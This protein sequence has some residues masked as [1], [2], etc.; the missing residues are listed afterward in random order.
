MHHVEIMTS[1]IVIHIVF[2]LANF[3]LTTTRSRISNGEIDIAYN[4][5]Q[6]SVLSNINFCR[7]RRLD[8][9]V[10]AGCIRLGDSVRAFIPL[11]SF[12][13]P[14]PADCISYAI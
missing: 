2:R 11:L 7:F 5:I 14:R 9:T 6:K 4:L 8:L 12:E 10:F 1:T 13:R 3:T